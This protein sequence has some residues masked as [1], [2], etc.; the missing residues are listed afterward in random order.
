MSAQDTGSGAWRRRKTAATRRRNRQGLR[1]P[2]SSPSRWDLPGSPAPPLLTCSA[3]PGR[4]GGVLGCVVRCLC[5]SCLRSPLT[6]RCLGLFRRF[7][8]GLFLFDGVNVT[9]N[10]ELD[11]KARSSSVREDGRRLCAGRRTTRTLLRAPVYLA[12]SLFFPIALSQ[13][14]FLC[15]YTVYKNSWCIYYT[16]KLIN[17]KKI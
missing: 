9:V 3:P 14:R 7:L 15:Y 4:A 6:V 8:A 12:I 5:F 10:G 2:I 1:M 17:F 13:S 11:G 16:Y